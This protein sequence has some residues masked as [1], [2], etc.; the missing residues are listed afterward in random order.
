MLSKFPFGL[1]CV[2]E[3]N[4]TVKV[5][6]GVYKCVIDGRFIPNINNLS[7]D[8]LAPWNDISTNRTSHTYNV[9][10]FKVGNVYKAVTKKTEGAEKIIKQ[11]YSKHCKFPVIRK[12]FSSSTI[13]DSVPSVASNAVIVYVVLKEFIF[14]PTKSSR[15]LPSKAAE[16][17]HELQ[18]KTPKAVVS[19]VNGNSGFMGDSRPVT[20]KQVEAKARN[21]PTRQAITN[22]GRPKFERSDVI[23]ALI[24]EG[25]FA[26]ARY[27][28]STDER[29][30]LANDASLALMVH[31]MLPKAVVLN[32]VRQV[33][34][35]KTLPKEQRLNAIK[36]LAQSK[37]YDEL[38]K[39]AICSGDTTF[40]LSRLFVTPLTFTTNH[41]KSS[42][43][44]QP[45]T[46]IACIMLSEHLT[47][48]DYAWMADQL[49]NRC[50]KLNLSLNSK[51]AW[52]F[53]SD[54]D[55]ALD[56]FLR[57]P[58]FSPP[59]VPL[60]CDEHFFRN[61]STWCKEDP[62]ILANF[63]GTKQGNTR[64]AGLMDHMDFDEF[65]NEVNNLSTSN[66][67][68]Q[69]PKL[70]D[71]TKSRARQIIAFDRH[72]L[73]Q[74]VAGG[75][76][77]QRGTSNGI[78]NLNQ[79][80][81][82]D[83]TFKPMMPVQDLI[84][85]LEKFVDGQLEQV[86]SALVSKHPLYLK[87]ASLFVGDAIWPTI[88]VE[89]KKESLASIGLHFTDKIPGFK[90]KAWDFP[91]E[92]APNLSEQERED[93]AR[94]SK[95]YA[96][97]KVTTEVNNYVVTK[98]EELAKVSILYMPAKCSC[99][100]VVG[101]RVVCVH[102]LAVANMFPDIKLLERMKEFLE[103]ETRD[104][105]VHRQTTTTAGMKK[106]TSRRHGD[107]ESRNKTTI[108]HNVVDL[109]TNR[110]LPGENEGIIS[111]PAKLKRVELPKEAASSSINKR[112]PS[113]PF[114]VLRPVPHTSST[115]ANIV[116][117]VQ[118]EPPSSILTSRATVYDKVLPSSPA[119]PN[120]Q[121]KRVPVSFQQDILRLKT[122]N[123]DVENEV[124]SYYSQHPNTVKPSYVN[125]KP[126]LLTLNNKIPDYKN[127]C[128]SHCKRSL[129]KHAKEIVVVHYESMSFTNSQTNAIQEGAGP[130]IFCVNLICVK[131][132]YPFATEKC[133][134]SNLNE[135][136]T[137]TTINTLMTTFE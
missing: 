95:Y 2:A 1:P 96:V 94:S 84:K 60:H 134:I 38:L 4:G 119:T 69:Y 120:S 53:I 116:T 88:T 27:K 40:K 68:K 107:K 42:S 115:P 124:Q 5:K 36:K 18:T 132:R 16:I 74:K 25:Y 56:A 129:G 131:S 85:C 50:K 109:T 55:P 39:S 73:M 29:I 20:R 100:F 47:F 62:V 81:K 121:P 64:T 33:N 46:Q 58:L 12:I 51:S 82:S 128:C 37:E 32:F 108:I 10:L 3:G 13:Y 14:T 114:K 45:S 76:G 118:S 105:R 97:M 44:N 125:H 133:F 79:V 19:I 35:I 63:F 17:G 111:P 7:Y 72:N 106:G 67:W 70:L 110:P 135:M 59:C 11:K 65:A 66:Q 78:E 80:C 9:G 117:E 48:A 102:I 30:F 52:S 90:V 86:G 101:K 99:K 83:V 15:L 91:K 34:H 43:T 71:W 75:F 24:D 21:T 22:K 8:S 136:D 137:A 122:D 26:Q 98:G 77:L 103:K 130:V 123:K 49:E 92:L 31:S 54:A 93:M 127:R 89:D 57:F 126:F 28:T 104:Q 41:L 23:E 6:R 112:L 113:V 87:D 61:V